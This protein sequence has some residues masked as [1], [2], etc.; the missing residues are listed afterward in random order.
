ML[1]IASSL[2]FVAGTGRRWQGLGH[3]LI[4]VPNGADATGWMN[5][6]DPLYASIADAW[7]RQVAA[8]TV[9]RYNHGLQRAMIGAAAVATRSDAVCGVRL[10]RCS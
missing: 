2:V 6:V 5:S 3:G 10:R 4:A 7:M 8:A 9:R 1:F